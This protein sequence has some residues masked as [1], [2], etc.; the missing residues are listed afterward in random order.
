MAQGA[1]NP[2]FF[3]GLVSLAD[4]PNVDSSS[5]LRI[6]SPTTLFE[7]L[8]VH[9]SQP[10]FWN[11]VE[12]SGSG[13]A[14]THSVNRASVTLSVS[15]LTA[16]RRVRQT[17]MRFA[18][19]PDKGQVIN[20]TS[21]IGPADLGI[22]KRLGAFDDQNGIFFEVKDGVVSVAVRSFVS[23]VVVDTK[24]EQADWNLDNFSGFGGALNPSGITLD[25]TK[26][27]VFI[28]EL[29]LGRVRIGSIVQGTNYYFHEFVYGNVITSAFMSTVMLPLRYEI[30][31]DGT[32]PV[33]SIETIASAVN[34]EG[35]IDPTGKLRSVSSMSPINA[36][37]IG[38]TYALFGIRLKSNYLGAYI[39][40]LSIGVTTI[41]PNDLL[42]WEIRRNPT[43]AGAFVFNDLPNSA[44]QVAIGDTVNSP[45]LNTVTGGTIVQSGFG[46]S[47][48]I[49]QELLENATHLGAAIDGTRDYAV[50]CIRPVNGINQDVFGALN[51][52]ETG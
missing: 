41:T 36:N 49:T 48:N 33:S 17:Y 32:G 46:L 3:S 24:V 40:F 47:Q 1:N 6:A 31:N 7:S 25:L 51:W 35:G 2:F 21:V 39:K 22:T 45:S 43:V 11:D 37:V 19:Q 30:E 29:G 15:N 20:V 27:Q 5:R 18:Y 38:N 42:V 28:I 34:R 16:G 4:S 50:I 9:D 26:L 44:V 8:L 12:V 10:F 14:S 52:R 13:T 23:G